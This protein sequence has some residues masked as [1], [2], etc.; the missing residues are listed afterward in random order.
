[1]Y[2]TFGGVRLGCGHVHADYAKALKCIETDRNRCYRQGG[3]TDRHVRRIDSAQEAKEY[4]T[5]R[6]PGVVAYE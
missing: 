2:T 3:Y 5:L 1:M 6:G 4:D